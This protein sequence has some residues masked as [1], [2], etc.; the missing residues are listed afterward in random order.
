MAMM[1]SASRDISRELKG[2]T[3]TATFTDDILLSAKHKEVLSKYHIHIDK[4]LFAYFFFFFYL[5][6]SLFI[7]FFLFFWCHEA[8]EIKTI[9][10]FFFF[11]FFFLADR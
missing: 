1:A 10:L 11:F 4:V 2:R 3:L 5:S 9:L 8:N 6:I 7:Y